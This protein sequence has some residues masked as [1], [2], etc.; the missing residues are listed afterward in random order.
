MSNETPNPKYRLLVLT[1]LS[2]ASDMALRNAVQLAKAINGK[3]DVFHAKAPTSVVKFDNQLSAMRSI[4][5]D[6]NKTQAKLE[7]DI[8]ELESAEGVRIGFKIA[9]GN[10]KNAIRE[11]IKETKPDIAVLGK[12]KSKIIGFLGDGITNFVLNQCSTNVLITDEEQV[13]HSFNDLSLGIFGDAI[14]KQGLEILNDLSKAGNKPIK[15]FSVGESA[16]ANV[17]NQEKRTISYVFPEGSNAMDG[18][19]SYVQKT[20]TQL[21]C[22]PS[23]KNKDQGGRQRKNIIDAS[24]RRMVQKVGIPVL[25]IAS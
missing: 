1:D 15:L 9:Y 11:H 5:H 3:V 25:F 7:N 2:K 22:I 24:V 20:Q 4:H 19:A 10:V 16:N 6:Y 12:R 23:S 17:S 14:E 8:Q 18:L 13:F 21:L